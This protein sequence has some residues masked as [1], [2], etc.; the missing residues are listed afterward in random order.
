MFRCQIKS[1]LQLGVR[2]N[3]QVD[4][5]I[6]RNRSRPLHVQVRLYCIAIHT[7]VVAINDHLR[8][9]HRKSEQFPELVHQVDVDV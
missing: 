3:H 2:S 1:T 4:R 6:G 7:R 5:R 9:I 8:R